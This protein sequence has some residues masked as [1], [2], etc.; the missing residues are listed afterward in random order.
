MMVM[1]DKLFF[2]PSH[3]ILG[4]YYIP[5]R[6]DWNYHIRKRHLTSKEKELFEKEFGEQIITD[7]QYF[8]WW[9]KI[10]SIH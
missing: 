6:N 4:G 2:K 7:D 5:V 9:K 1:A 8:E 3:S 10:H